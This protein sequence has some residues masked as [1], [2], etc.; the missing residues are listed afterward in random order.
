MQDRSCRAFGPQPNQA[1]IESVCK[2]YNKSI[3][4]HF[5][6]FCQRRLPAHIPCCRMPQNNNYFAKEKTHVPLISKNLRN[7]LLTRTFFTCSGQMS[8]LK[9]KYPDSQSVFCGQ[10]KERDR[11]LQQRDFTCKV[12]LLVQSVQNAL[13][14]AFCCEVISQGLALGSRVCIWTALSRG[15]TAVEKDMAEDFT[16]YKQRDCQNKPSTTFKVVNPDENF[17]TWTANKV[18]FPRIAKLGKK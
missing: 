9:L 1:I 8:G 14:S 4:L 17:L 13:Q 10:Q 15:C 18:I 16:N 2:I 7:F 12:R 11:A 3:F 6:F 5:N